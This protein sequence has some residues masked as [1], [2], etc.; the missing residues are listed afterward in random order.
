MMELRFENI[1][2][3]RQS[4]GLAPS[5]FGVPLGAFLSIVGGTP[6]LRAEILDTLAGFK[7]PVAGSIHFCGRPIQTLVPHERPLTVIFKEGNLFNQLTLVDN[8]TL[9]IQ[10]T[11]H[12]RDVERR[13]VEGVM[14]YVGLKGL[15]H[16]YPE[17]INQNF[18]QRASLARSL[19]AGKPLLLLDEP[20]EG[21]DGEE[22][23]AFVSLLRKAHVAFRLTVVMTVASWEDAHGLSSHVALFQEGKLS[24]VEEAC[25]FFQQ[26]QED[27]YGTKPFLKTRS[28]PGPSFSARA[29]T[30]A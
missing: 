6:S 1:V 22:K 29:N 3:E 23:S 2:L 27:T 19:I 17:D 4:G 11:L 25:H 24:H 20:F 12:L 14:E 13:K 26:V 16:T 5:S 10:G 21:L 8:I 7:I 15:G 30:L 18:R 9:G 28:V